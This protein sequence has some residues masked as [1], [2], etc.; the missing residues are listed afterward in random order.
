MTE[1]KIEFKDFETAL[2]RLEEITG[3]LEAGDASLEEAI[4]LYTEGI[5][6]AAF[7]SRKLSDSEK[8]I[9]I[10]KE[11][12]QEMIERAFDEERENGD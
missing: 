4:D 8:R 3:Q 2:E 6:I 7:C 9:L 11:K 10:L 12:N 5:Q 1:P